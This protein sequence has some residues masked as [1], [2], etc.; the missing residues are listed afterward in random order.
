M[1]QKATG[2]VEISV[3]IPCYNQASF[4]AE[5]IDSVLRQSFQ[6]TSIIVV[7]DGST[8][9]TDAVIGKYPCV[10]RISQPNSG[11]AAA[12]NSGLKASQ[13]RYAVFLDADDV[14]L[15]NALEIGVR[16]LND[17]PEWAFVSGGFRYVAENGSAISNPVIAKYSND[18]FAMLLRGN[19]IAMGLR[20]FIDGK[21]S[22]K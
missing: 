11:L 18:N 14:L 17:H 15:P 6:N 22:N 20:L 7:N 3:I 13:G 9:D 10:S 4:L 1:E 2:K 12:R 19:Y 8:D 5:A 21:C 16:M